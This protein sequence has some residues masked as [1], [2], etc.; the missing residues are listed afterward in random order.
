M[1]WNSKLIT[2][3]CALRLTMGTQLWVDVSRN[4]KGDFQAHLRCNRCG[5]SAGMFWSEGASAPMLTSTDDIIS[6]VLRHLVM[7]HDISLSGS[8]NERDNRKGN[9]RSGTAE[10]AG[11]SP[12]SDSDST[13]DT[14]YRSRHK[15][16]AASREREPEE[17]DSQ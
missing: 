3:E 4:S 5:K 14:N 1:E 17:D 15:A 2:P 9:D 7:A 12:D 6:S 16:S 11:N 8:K 10:A 13:G